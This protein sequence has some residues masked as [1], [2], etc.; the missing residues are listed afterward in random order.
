MAT[1]K[2]KIVSKAIEIL[3]LNS[4]GVRYSDLVR[5]IQEEIPDIPVNTIHGTVWNLETRVPT[6]IYKPARGLFRHIK[7]KRN[8]NFLQ[9]LK[10]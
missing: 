8:E 10:K 3:K 6:E 2:E 5:K 1:K 9:K 4:N 7:F